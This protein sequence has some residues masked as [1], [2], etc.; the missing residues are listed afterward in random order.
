MLKEKYNETLEQRVKEEASEEYKNLIVSI[1]QCNRNTSSTVDH[2]DVKKDV[3]DLYKAGEDKWGT[4]TFNKYL[5][6]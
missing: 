1:L 3:K 2:N 6:Y 5:I 4:G